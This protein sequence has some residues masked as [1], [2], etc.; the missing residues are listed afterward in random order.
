MRSRNPGTAFSRREPV[1]HF[2]LEK[3]GDN[4]AALL[5]IVGVVFSQTAPK[6]SEDNTGRLPCRRANGDYVLARDSFSSFY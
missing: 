3:G 4:G 1:S 6:V 5:A 2:I